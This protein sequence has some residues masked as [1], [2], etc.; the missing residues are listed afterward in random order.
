M[1]RMETRQERVLAGG[2]QSAVML[3]WVDMLMISHLYIPWGA[4]V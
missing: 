3:W 4:F 1:R 2:S